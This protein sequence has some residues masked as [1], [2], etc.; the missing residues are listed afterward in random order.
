[1]NKFNNL[2][3]GIKQETVKEPSKVK[4]TERSNSK[5]DHTNK[6]S[7]ASVLQKPKPQ[8][9]EPKK[10]TVNFRDPPK[11]RQSQQNTERNKQQDKPKANNLQ[12][13]TFHEE[14]GKQTLSQSK[15]VQ[16]ASFLLEGGDQILSH[17]VEGI[18]QVTATTNALKEQLQILMDQHKPTH[19]K[20]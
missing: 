18:E 5:T 9:Q 19:S 7:Y 10:N 20:M 17:L 13:A 16:G 14:G 1:M 15:N 4:S 8:A 3:Y 11:E 2:K 12:N 6:P